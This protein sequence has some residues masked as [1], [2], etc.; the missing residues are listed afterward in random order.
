MNIVPTREKH[1]ATL[2]IVS[3]AFSCACVSGAISMDIG[4][5][6]GGPSLAQKSE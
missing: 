1:D 5:L 6:R 2:S 3:K 4:S